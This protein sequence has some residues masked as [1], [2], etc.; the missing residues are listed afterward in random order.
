VD[1]EGL[2]TDKA[3]RVSVLM[4]AH[5]AGPYFSA[6]INSILN[7]TFRDFEFLIVAYLGSPEVKDF[8]CEH[9]PDE[10]RIRVIEVP[11][12]GGLGF[13]L[14]TGTGQSR[15]EYIARMDGDDVSY[16]ERLREQVEYM[17]AHPNLAVLGCRIDLIDAKS[18][19]ID[20]EYP[21]YETDAEIRRILPFRNPM[22]HPALMFRKTAL[23]NV[24]GYMF[25]HTAE[26][27]EMMLRIARQA[28][29]HFYNLDKTLFS[30]RRHE[31]QV[32]NP[33]RIGTAF[34]VRGGILFSE[35]LRTHSPKYL[36]SMILIHPWLYRAR[37]TLRNWIKGSSA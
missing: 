26:D 37:I 28:E 31:N 22:P 10:T 30:Y 2:V 24:N 3:P 25:G 17:D 32:T 35:F 4:E 5:T 11:A 27:H 8:I 13:A 6:A 18:N 29:L 9:Y 21:Y 33:K 1:I 20:R 16:P 14:N 34:S 19:K 7:Q 15:G 36:A 12:L 23:Y